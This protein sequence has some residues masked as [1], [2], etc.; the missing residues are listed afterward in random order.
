MPQQTLS[1]SILTTVSSFDA[2]IC[3]GGLVGAS[4]ALALAQLNLSVALVEAEPSYG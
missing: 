3:G 4:L 1:T 2:L